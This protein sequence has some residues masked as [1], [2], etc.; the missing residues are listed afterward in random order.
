MTSLKFSTLNLRDDEQ[1]RE[2]L[3]KVREVTTDGE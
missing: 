2:F 1:E 3:D